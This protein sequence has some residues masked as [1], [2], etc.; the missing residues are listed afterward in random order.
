[1]ALFVSTDYLMQV[2]PKH[3]PVSCLNKRCKKL[4]FF[5]KDFFSKCK[6]KTEDKPKNWNKKQRILL[7]FLKKSF[8]E[9]FIFFQKQP[10]RGVPKTFH[11]LK[12]LKFTIVKDFFSKCE[13][14]RNFLR[15]SRKLLIFCSVSEIPWLWFSKIR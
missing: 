9:N 12:K 7:H 5:V 8:A 14:I 1:M 3:I 10:S 11:H 15:I 6:L 2:G 13:Q 4:K